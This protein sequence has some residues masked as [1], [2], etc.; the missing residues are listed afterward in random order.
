MKG[1]K[2][3]GE[4]IE[5]KSDG[6]TDGGRR[7]REEKRKGEFVKTNG[8]QEGNG[9]KEVRQP[10]THTEMDRQTDGETRGT[11]DTGRRHPAECNAIGAAPVQRGEAVARGHAETWRRDH[12]QR[13]P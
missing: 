8:G 9:E 11:N 1:K 6:E 3:E 7:K 10:V 13:R 12:A 4:E 2:D 5:T